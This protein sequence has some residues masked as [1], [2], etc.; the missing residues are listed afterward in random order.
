[1]INTATTTTIAMTVEK[2]PL[3]TKIEPDIHFIQLQSQYSRNNGTLHVV[4]VLRNGQ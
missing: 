4:E 3:S 2:C 1:M